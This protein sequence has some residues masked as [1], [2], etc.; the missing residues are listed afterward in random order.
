MS[1]VCQQDQLGLDGHG[2]Y[3]QAAAYAKEVPSYGRLGEHFNMG[4]GQGLIF[5]RV[6]GKIF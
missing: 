2:S 4:R 1:I 3:W 6:D 5:E